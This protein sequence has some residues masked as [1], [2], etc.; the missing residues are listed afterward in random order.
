MLH[1]MVMS[2]LLMV[3]RLGLSVILLQRHPEE[4]ESV[5]TFFAEGSQEKE[6][7]S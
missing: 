4:T 3:C 1:I 2:S 6:T 5:S 7:F